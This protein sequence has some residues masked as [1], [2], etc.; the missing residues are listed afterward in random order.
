MLLPA[1][2]SISQASAGLASRTCDIVVADRCLCPSISRGYGT[3]DGYITGETGNQLKEIKWRIKRLFH[4]AHVSPI[5][6]GKSIMWNMDRCRDRQTGR[7]MMERWSLWDSL[8]MQ[9][10]QK[11]FT[12]NWIVLELNLLSLKMNRFNQSNYVNTTAI[13]FVSPWNHIYI[14]YCWMCSINTGTD[15][16]LDTIYLELYWRHWP[17]RIQKHLQFLET[18]KTNKILNKTRGITE[19]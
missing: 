9:A 1:R 13:I 15:I 18:W 16:S 5:L 4:R 2:L 12:V 11:Y 8:L 10:S 7:Q 6:A 14:T 19:N 3:T 17:V